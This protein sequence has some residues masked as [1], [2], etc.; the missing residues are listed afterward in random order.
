MNS[1]ILISAAELNDLLRNESAT[2]VDCRFDLVNTDKG[3][4]DW[5][6]AHVPGAAYAHLDDDL[7]APVQ[8]HTGRHP[9]PEVGAFAAFLAAAGWSGDKLLVAYD[10][11]SNAI[12][13]RLWWMMRFYGKKAALLDGG[14]ASWLD[15]GYPLESG[16][17][18]VTPSVPETL[19]PD[20][21]MIVSAEA[22]KA[23]LNTGAEP[24]IDARA[25]DRYSGK[26]EPLDSRAG[27]IPGALN[28][29]FTLNL[30]SS[31]RFKPAV[32]LRSEFEALLANTRA[33]KVVHS[34]GSGVTACHNLFAME[35]AG[36][37]GSRLY[38]GSWSHWITD[39]E[40]P[41]ATGQ[42]S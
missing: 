33:D 2:V 24:V 41:I 42:A 6:K 36:F 20:P 40:R 16:N 29:P 14:Y 21:D 12:S 11:G 8:P 25:P 35:L 22:I 5:L 4:A 13:A 15:A 27:H 34:C 23:H 28:R 38:P 3:R 39:P 17:P 19:E 32:E 1:E 10:N 26:V 31:G 30:D 18:Q 7:A 37:A 9:L